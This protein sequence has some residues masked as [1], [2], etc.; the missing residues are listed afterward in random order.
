MLLEKLRRSFI[1]LE[2]FACPL[3][4]LSLVAQV[5]ILL[6]QFLNLILAQLVQPITLRDHH[7]C[8][9]HGRV[10]LAFPLTH[11][12]ALEASQAA[13]VLVALQSGEERVVQSEGRIIHQ[14]VAGFH[15]GG[16]LGGINF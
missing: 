16:P 3:H 12:P 14:G 8:V 11:V 6:K 13:S 10:P 4:N 2:K 1:A 5:L 9:S 15:C 7:F